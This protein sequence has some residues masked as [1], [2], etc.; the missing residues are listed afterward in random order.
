[1]ILDPLQSN[2]P[3]LNNH[4][5]RPIYLVNIQRQ[6]PT[7]RSSHGDRYHQPNT[8]HST[9][10]IGK[11]IVSCTGVLVALVLL[12]FL[13]YLGLFGMAAYFILSNF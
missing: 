2:E 5:R 4:L 10:W 8:L 13:V 7:R 6:R 1:M 12:G 9:G 3:R 11:V